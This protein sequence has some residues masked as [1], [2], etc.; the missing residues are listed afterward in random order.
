DADGVTFAIIVDSTTNISRLQKKICDSSTGN[1]DC[2]FVIP[3]KYQ[4]IKHFISEYDAVQTLMQTVNDDPVLFEDYEVIYEDLRDVLRS[5]IGVYT[6]PEKHGAIY[7]HNGK[8]KKIVRKSG[9]TKL[10]SDICDDIF[11]LTPTINNEMINKDEPTNVT[12]HSREKIVSGLL[13]TNLEPN[14]GLSGN[15]QEVSIMRST[16]INTNILVQNDSMIKLNLSPEDPLL[17]GLL[18]SIEEFIVGTRK[19]TKKNFKLLYDELIGA[20]LKIGLRK[21]LIPIYLSVVIHKYKQDIIICDQIGQ[22][23][24]TADTIEQINSKPELFT[25]SYINWSPQK[26]KYVSSLEELFANYSSD[27]NASTSYDHVLLL[28]KRWYM[29]LPK[30]SKNVRVIN[31]ITITK[32]DRGLISELRKN[33]GSYDF[34]FDNLPRNYGLSGVGK[35]LVKHIEKTKQIYDNAL[36]CLKNELAQILR[37]TFCTLDSSNCEKMSLTSIIRDWCEKLEPEAFEQLFSDGTNRCLKLFNEVTNDEDAFIEKTAK[38]ATDLRIED[39]DEDIITLFENNIKQY[40]ETAESFHHEKERDISPNSDEDYELIFK[41]KNGD[42]IIKRF[43]KVEDSSR[44]EL[45]YNAICSQ[46]DSMG[47]AITEQE[48]RQILMEIL[49]KMC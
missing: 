21:G 22:V 28:M 27:D 20:K 40:R 6:R 48:K 49:K 45:L 36:E 25:L 3:K 11:E 5:F 9:L 43:A 4:E 18:A 29:S 38:M 31:G 30:Y 8:K 42:K 47:Q 33:T 2:V 46:L 23:P 12:K 39:W 16:L 32:K 14:L 35:T 19:K 24:L 13:R 41:E 7:I 10:L 26:E 44:G 37:N 17:A 15:G 34:V 1:K